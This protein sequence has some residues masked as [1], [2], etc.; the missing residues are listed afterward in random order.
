MPRSP[1]D[2]VTDP[3]VGGGAGQLRSLLKC[4][5]RA[6]SSPYL[7]HVGPLIGRLVAGAIAAGMIIRTCQ[8][9]NEKKPT[10][11]FA[12]PSPHRLLP[13][14]LFVFLLSG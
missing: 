13:S 11:R 4:L 9:L 12:R 14:E 5:P 10:E 2:R 3:A 1:H 7:G 8:G 6:G